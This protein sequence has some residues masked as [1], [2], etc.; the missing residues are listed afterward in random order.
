MRRLVTPRFSAPVL[1]VSMMLMAAFVAV[2][3]AGPTP[4]QTRQ[5]NISADQQSF[6]ELGR[7]R[8]S[9]DVRVVYKDVRINT[10][11]ATLE[12]NAVGEPDVATFFNRPLAKR[13]VEPGPD[14]K[15]PG[16]DHLRANVIKILLA[17]NIMRAEGD[18]ISNIHT[19]AQSPVVIEA[20]IQEFDNVQKTVKAT[21][22][23]QV[24]YE[25][26]RIYSP[27]AMLWIDEQ[28]RGKRVVFTGGSKAIQEQS[29]INS[30]KLTILVESGNLLAEN[31][32]KTDVK[33]ESKSPDS[34]SR[35]FIE[36]DFQQYDKA[37][38][39]MLAS[40]NVKI[41]YGDYR[42][43][44]PKATFRMND[45]AVET[46][47]ITGRAR[48]ITDTRHVEADKIVIT[49]DPKHFDAV[50][51]VKSKFLTQQDSPASSGATGASATPSTPASSG[52]S[53]SSGGTSPEAG[54]ATEPR[55]TAPSDDYLE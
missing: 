40:G 18:S 10:D 2:S 24:D 46:I 9:G 14:V 42:A 1:V 38:D 47:F 39:T 52:T 49:T 48:I 19:A 32:V 21:G 27:L 13:I 44:G 28:G 35:V 50:G 15:F 11:L 51:N 43:F 30:E 12:M 20:E 54:P 6:D 8:F 3:L 26:T 45:G 33:T 4:E 53:A 23:V 5:V 7:T 17:E 41:L 36:S 25:Q 55:N 29:V 22:S 16:E 31:N 34:P 37:S